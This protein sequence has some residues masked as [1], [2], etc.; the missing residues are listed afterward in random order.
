LK[1]VISNLLVPGD[2]AFDNGQK[3]QC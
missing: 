2:P 3:R 1:F